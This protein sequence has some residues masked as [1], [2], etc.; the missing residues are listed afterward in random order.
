MGLV[1]EENG[2]AD[3]LGIGKNKKY[4]RMGSELHD[5]DDDFDDD[6]IHYQRQL[7]KGKS[8]RRYVYACAVFASLNN[9]LL[10]YGNDTVFVSL[11]CFLAAV[12]DVRDQFFTMYIRLYMLF[13]SFDLLF[14]SFSLSHLTWLFYLIVGKGKRKFPI[15]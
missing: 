13:S 9:V 1:G 7:E 8:T 15:C 14:S 5:D 2:S 6:L 10:G 11:F 4:K 12:I 3:S